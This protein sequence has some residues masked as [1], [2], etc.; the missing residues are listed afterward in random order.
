[1]D[2]AHD[3][4]RLMQYLA[5]YIAIRNAHF[6]LALILINYIASK[7]KRLQKSQSKLTRIPED[8]LKK[9]IE[10]RCTK[11]INLVDYNCCVVVDSGIYNLKCTSWSYICCLGSR[12]KY[13]VLIVPLEIGSANLFASE[14]ACFNI[15][16]T[17][18]TGKH[19][20]YFVGNEKYLYFTLNSL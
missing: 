18:N 12:R 3:N 11:D 7:L 8:I 10:S 9:L 19:S 17:L 15:E 2:L 1:M 16:S 4:V 6:L 20:C 14:T 13:K 5:K